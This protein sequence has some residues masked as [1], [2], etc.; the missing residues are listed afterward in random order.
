M[1]GERGF[2]LLEVLVAFVILGMAISLLLQGAF[3]GLHSADVAGRYAEAVARAR[4]H[5]AALGTGL[6]AGDTQGDDGSAYHWRVRVVP[7]RST[8]IAS[9]VVN[10]VPATHATLYSVSV[11]ISWREGGR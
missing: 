10:G 4:S 8:L 7:V 5:L 9:D 6:V 1:R 2:T 3:G 11:A